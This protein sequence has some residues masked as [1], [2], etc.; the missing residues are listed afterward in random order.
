MHAYKY[1][2][3]SYS[4]R[5]SIMRIKKKRVARQM[6]DLFRS[7]LATSVYSREIRVRESDRRD[8]IAITRT[9]PRIH[10]I[11]VFRPVKGYTLRNDVHE[12][13]CAYERRE[14]RFKP[15]VDAA[16]D[17]ARLCVRSARVQS[18]RLI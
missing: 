6:R 5:D 7:K 12:R 18:S 4:F 3:Y 11:P 17:A 16:A 15:K 14:N 9:T 13:A 1:R 2:T 8:V 10:E